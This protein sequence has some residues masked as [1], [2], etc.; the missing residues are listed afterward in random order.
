[1]PPTVP[2][3]PPRMPSRRCRRPRSPVQHRSGSRYALGS[4]LPLGVSPYATEIHNGPPPENFSQWVGIV[5]GPSSGGRS[6]RE[7]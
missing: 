3:G 7:T 1:M 4:A 6:S 2:S 5:G